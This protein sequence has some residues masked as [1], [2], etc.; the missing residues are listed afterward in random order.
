MGGV[1]EDGGFFDLPDPKNE[2]TAPIFHFLGPKRRTPHFPPSRPEEWT[3]NPPGTS[4]SDSSSGHQLL[5]A[6]LRSGSSDRSS[7]L[8]IGPKIEIGPLHGKTFSFVVIFSSASVIAVICCCRRSKS[9]FYL[10]AILFAS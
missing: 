6:I 8:K 3:N 5:S 2:L 9:N 10:V 4:S 1:F 7:T